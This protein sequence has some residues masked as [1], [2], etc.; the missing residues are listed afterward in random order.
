MK[1]DLGLINLMI[2]VLGLRNYQIDT[3]FY[4]F[5]EVGGGFKELPDS[6]LESI[7]L[8][9][10]GNMLHFQ[11]PVF[12]SV[13]VIDSHSCLNNFVKLVLQ[14]LIDSFHPSVASFRFW[15]IRLKW[16][17]NGWNMTTSSGWKTGVCGGRQ[18][19]W[20]FFLL[21]KLIESIERWEPW[22]WSM[23]SFGPWM[24]VG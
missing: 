8:L 9:S 1:V 16:A 14:Q 11:K 22:P 5:D 15:F 18:Y 13:T 24:F 23:R 7:A 6:W 19:M 20:M 21:H 17:F 2:L 10:R 4:E 3:G 12:I